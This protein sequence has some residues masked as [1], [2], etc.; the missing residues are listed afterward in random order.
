MISNFRQSSESSKNFFYIVTNPPSGP[1]LK[2]P[3][4]DL[5][6]DINM[7]NQYSIESLAFLW[8]LC[9][10][11]CLFKY[12]FEIGLFELAWGAQLARLI[13]CR[14]V[15]WRLLRMDSPVPSPPLSAFLLLPL[16]F[17][18][19]IS[20]KANKVMLRRWQGGRPPKCKVCAITQIQVAP[21]K[22][23]LIHQLMVYR[24]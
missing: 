14:P 16:S 19:S 9:T 12:V 22:I 11:V 24:R 5:L 4:L 20:S 13:K 17:S 10:G 18:V 3:G 6:L 8:F 2:T 21:L 7:W 15:A 1:C 23:A